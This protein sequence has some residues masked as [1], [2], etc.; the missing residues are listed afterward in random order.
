LRQL[1]PVGD[2][3]KRSWVLVGIDETIRRGVFGGRPVN[4]LPSDVGRG[5]SIFTAVEE[6]LA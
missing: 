6:Q 2:G 1:H 4:P 3:A 5:P